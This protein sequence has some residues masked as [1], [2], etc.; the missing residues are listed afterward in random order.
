MKTL[1]DLVRMTE[2][3]R[4]INARF[5]RIIGYKT[6]IDKN[7]V[8]TAVAKTFTP[9]EYT[10]GHKV[11]RAKDQNRYTSSIKFLKKGTMNVKVSCSCPDYCFRFEFANHT[12]GASDI[13]YSN[14]EPP[15]ETNPNYN[16]GLCL[17]G[18]TLV[19]TKNYGELA[20]KDLSTGMRV[21]TI[22]GWAT[23][24]DVMFMGHKFVY[25]VR[26]NRGGHVFT[27]TGDHLV[28]AFGDDHFEWKP[29]HSLVYGD[30]L[31]ELGRKPGWLETLIYGWLGLARKTLTED[32]IKDPAQP[33]EA[34][35]L[36]RQLWTNQDVVQHRFIG[37]KAREHA[38]P[39]YD[40][41]TTHGHFLANGIIV[42]NCKHLVRLRMH[43]KEKH[44]F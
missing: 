1:G 6:G 31:Y 27:A 9:L 2:R 11:V 42:H 23:I 16:P 30:T 4:R 7:G 43:I 37:L 20:I 40:I 12:V 41:Q 21:R 38:E 25:E 29:V 22:H 3:M 26:T 13:I 8:P 5:V 32:L 36:Y 19:M 14:G 35:R 44:G 39:V 15:D 34:L 28:L 18:D 33:Y 10:I 24:Q 17:T